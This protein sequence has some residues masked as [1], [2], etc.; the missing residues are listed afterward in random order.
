[1]VVVALVAIAGLA[2]SNG[3]STAL[4]SAEQQ[5]VQLVKLSEHVH[6]AALSGTAYLVGHAP[7][8]RAALVKASQEVDVELAS[9]IVSS[10]PSAQEDTSL[11]AALGAWRTSADVRSTVIASAADG[12]FVGEG[13][14]TI[15][16]NLNRALGAVTAHLQT[17]E[18]VSAAD[19]S[20]RQKQRDATQTLSAIAIAVA[21]GIA[22]IGALWLLRL[23]HDGREAVRRRE[24]RLSSLV[25]NA[26]DGILV[27]DK[28]RQ[29]AF[30]T[31][32]FS[33]EFFDA[34][35]Q[36][37][38]F[39]GLIHADDREQTEKA[40]SRVLTGGR[41]TVS[42]VE[43]RLRRR[44]GEW[45]HVWTKL[46]NRLDDP[47][48]AGVV[49]NV[50][51]VSDRHEFEKQLTHQAL[52]DGLTGLPNRDLLRSRMDR[53]SSTA[54]GRP[55]F[56]VLYLDCDDFKRVN[57]VFGHAAGDRF[58]TEL[59]ERLAACVR[60]EDTVARLG[61]D[62][63]AILLE[64]T[65]AGG[66]LLAAKRILLALQVP[67]V[68]DGKEVHPSV[69]IG[70][71]SGHPV[72]FHADTLLADADLAMYFAKRAGKGGYRV[73][74]DVMRSELLTRLELG[75]EL[76]AAVESESLHVAYQPIID[77]QSGA[78]VG[79]EALARWNHQS[80]GAVGPDVFIPL[81]EE[82]GL[83][84]QIDEW[85]LRE[86]CTT[87]RAWSEHGMPFRM[88]VNLS[89]HDLAQPNLLERVSAILA[90]TGFPPCDLELELT[91]GVAIN[92]STDAQA[93]LESLK[94]LGI[95]LAIDDFGTGYSALSRLRRLPFDRL[96]IDKAFVDDIGLTQ[97]APLLV[98]T[99]LDMAH[100]LGLEVVAEGVETSTQADYLRRR[101]CDFAQG[102][103]F[104][105]PMGEAELGSLIARQVSGPRSDLIPA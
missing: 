5:G 73:F 60:P 28:R 88:A 22:F 97:S 58:L 93:V 55:E 78:I 94:A 17:A 50:T 2:A 24:R 6:D 27:L 39:D 41:G 64:N 69:S 12:S 15:E 71:A 9:L 35:S 89:G 100:V 96:K 43:A 48:V 8:D 54:A 34:T 37:M 53:A 91:E 23:L 14:S 83:V 32:S 62:E 51:D 25:E 10:A 95:R 56:S 74:D 52:H 16:D 92:E 59:S 75:E 47:A 31:P 61:G 19:V 33:D 104:N 46:T 11:A 85:I 18:G 29:V 86:A 81:A 7:D 87:G 4:Q 72:G 98:D 79:A 45:R 101:H 21:I 65:G 80:R 99:I 77:M 76:R 103:L 105:R 57:D 13:R 70:L 20:G 66:A 67:M 3:A 49:L 42:E 68:L 1:M 36:A 30:V 63:F 82:L 44:D 26:S 38:D 102:Y 90:D 84:G 40:W